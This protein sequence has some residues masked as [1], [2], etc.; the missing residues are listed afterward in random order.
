MCAC[1]GGRAGAQLWQAGDLWRGC[2]GGP[3]GGTSLP[4]GHTGIKVQRTTKKKWREE[5]QGMCQWYPGLST[6]Q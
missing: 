5:E 2:H 6:K 1:V 4:Q 3:D